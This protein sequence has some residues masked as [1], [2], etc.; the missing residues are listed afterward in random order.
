MEKKYVKGIGGF[1]LVYILYSCVSLFFFIATSIQT[2][3][4]LAQYLSYNDWRTQYFEVYSIAFSVF[5]FIHILLLIFYRRKISVD[6]TITFYITSIC[7]GWINFPV[8]NKIFTTIF[9]TQ[10]GFNILIL[11]S[12]LSIFIIFYFKKSMRIKNTYFIDDINSQNDIETQFQLGIIYFHGQNV[13]QDYYKAREYF[14]KAATQ[15][16]P[17]AQKNLGVIYA[18]GYGVRQDYNKARYWWEKAAAQNHSGAQS[19]LGCLYANGHGV[20]R[21]Y[22]MARYWWEKAAAQGNAAA[23]Y[24][25][26]LMHEYG[27]GVRQNFATAK[28][29]YGRA[30]DNGEQDGCDAYARLNR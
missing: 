14:E 2:H 12:L 11:S 22:N 16:H 24:S 3:N 26:G 6:I 29:W 18:Q 20:P 15:N 23:Q 13:P 19:C 1:L 30:C 17:T 21:D 10:Q 25:L 28:E 4:I 7:I 8:F 9:Q 27:H 5:N